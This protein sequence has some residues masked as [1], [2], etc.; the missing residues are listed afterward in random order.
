MQFDSCSYLLFLPLTVL[1]YWLCPGRWRFAV[2]LAASYLFYG[3]SDFRLTA[4]ILAVT[5]VSYTAGLAMKRTGRRKGWL[6]LTIVACLGALGYFKYANFF[7]QVLRGIA[8]GDWEAWDIILPVGI[9]FYTFQAMSYVIDVYRGD[10]E[11]ES[12][13]GFYALYL[14]FFPQLVAGPIERAKELLPQLRTRQQWNPGN[15]QTGC[16]LLLDGFFRKIVIADLCA[17]VVQRVYELEAF[18]GFSV[19]AATVLFAIQ[20]YCDFSGY[21]RIAQGSARLLGIRLMENFDRPYLAGSLKD[22]WRRWHISLSNWFTD[23]VYIPMGGSRRGKARQIAATMT[24]FTLSGLWHGA[25]WTFLLWGVYHGALLTAQNLLQSRK[26]RRTLPVWLSRILT[27]GLVC[28]GWAFF[29]A[30]QV[31]TAVS[32]LQALVS[33]WRVSFEVLGI[34]WT[35]VLVIGGAVAALPALE[36]KR[37]DTG[38]FFWVW[39]LTA[40]AAAWLIRLASGGANT[41]IYFQF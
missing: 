10:L 20:I 40:I 37:Q 1:A 30:P 3:W 6:L 29:R 38:T 27:F 13:F 33:P 34:T 41:F 12:H 16:R 31:S 32:M 17:P 25:N 5:A 22:F 36:R 8:G 26:P 24:V 9:S 14:S 35:D 23:Y 28:I 4:L 18:E 19:F 2:L 7:G 15:F 11:P 39:V 21:S